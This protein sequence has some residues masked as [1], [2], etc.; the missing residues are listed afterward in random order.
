MNKWIEQAQSELGELDERIHKLGEFF[1]TD[2]FQ[3]L[4]SVNRNTLGSQFLAMNQ[5]A[6]CLRVRLL[7]A[8][9]AETELKDESNEQSDPAT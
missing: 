9:T 5:Y 8:N 4:D 2:T 1:S 3:S 6:A 7:L